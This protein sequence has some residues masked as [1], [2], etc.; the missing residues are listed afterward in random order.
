MGRLAR[1]AGW[2]IAWALSGCSGFG[3]GGDGDGDGLSDA[4]EASIG[5]DP[6]KVDSDGDGKRDGDELRLLGT[7]PLKRDTD[8]DGVADGAEVKNGT[9]PKVADAKP[10][11]GDVQAAPSTRVGPDGAPVDPKSDPFMHPG[12]EPRQP[13]VGEAPADVWQCQNASKGHWTIAL[14][15][16]YKVDGATFKMGAQ[17][18]DPR[19]PNYDP[20][21]EPD[22]A[23]VRDVTVSSFWIQ[24]N[25]VAAITWRHCVEAGVCKAADAMAAGALLNASDEAR[26][27]HPANGVSWAGANTLCGWLGGRLPTEAEWELAARGTDGRRFPWGNDATCGYSR[28]RLGREGETANAVCTGTGTRL[29][30]DNPLTGIGG[31]THLAGNV[32]EWTADWYA[33]YD[34]AQ[35][36]DPRGPA[37]GKSRVQRG[38]GWLSESPRE[39]RSAG[40]AAVPPDQLLP[41][42]GFRCVWTGRPG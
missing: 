23:P 28:D 20:D 26:N 22:E 1:R 2:G 41:D 39:M 15:C 36:T 13:S 42:V 40:R 31:A 16:F 24:R 37:A 5:T 30:T 33:P 32:W 7:D 14:A 34:P 11:G 4:E 25:E 9:D 17:S 35:T 6:T 12:P 38:G 8:G 18:A 27:E 19:G 10:A 3:G 29:V 21:A